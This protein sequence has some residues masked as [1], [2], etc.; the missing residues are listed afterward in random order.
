MNVTKF[1][2][3]LMFTFSIA[4]VK[5]YLGLQRSDDFNAVYVGIWWAFA[6]C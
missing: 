3:H 2:R 4:D 1:G 5:A 6:E